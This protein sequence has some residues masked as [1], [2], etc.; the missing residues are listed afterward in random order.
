MSSSCHDS[1]TWEGTVGFVWSASRGSG[2][3]AGWQ[4]H[5]LILALHVARYKSK[6]PGYQLLQR[7]GPLLPDAL[8]KWWVITTE[9]AATWQQDQLRPPHIAAGEPSWRLTAVLLSLNQTDRL[10]T[11][12]KVGMCVNSTSPPHRQRKICTRTIMS[13]KKWVYIFFLSPVMK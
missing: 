3:V 7:G 9:H 2:R 12:C 10:R 4:F 6:V 5:H 13:L 11:E 1:G 8:D